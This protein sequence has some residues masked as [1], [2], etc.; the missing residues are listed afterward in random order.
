VEERVVVES[1][2]DLAKLTEFAFASRKY[3][4]YMHPRMVECGGCNL[5]YA[6][7]AISREVL[8]GAYAEAAFDSGQESHFASETY[9]GL[10]AAEFDSIPQR[11]SAL[12]IGAGDGSFL[13]KL[14]SLGFEEVVGVE[15]S[16]AP[17]S[18]AREN[19]RQ[20]IR[21]DVFRAS[22]FTPARFEL[23]TC[24]QVLEH[25]PEP[26]DLIKDIYSLLKP[27]GHFITVTHNLEALSARLLGPKSPIFD[28]EHL[29]LF[30]QK[31]LET[32]LVRAGFTNVRVVRLWNRYPIHYWLK[33]FPIPR[34]AKLSLVEASRRL[35]FGELACSLPAGNIV[36]VGV[37]AL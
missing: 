24:F 36:A 23:I 30:S 1:N 29:Q 4:E 21:H 13:E 26:L 3:P 32:L 31:T 33:L 22:D 20:M 25:I 5:V 2:I 12:D 15:P 6:S 7:P 10:V 17:I 28:I 16:A 34:V 18:A 14:M 37:K 11:H 35:K 19:I 8:C 27:G 9:G